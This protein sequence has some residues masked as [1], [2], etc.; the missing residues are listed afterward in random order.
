MRVLFQLSAIALRQV[1]GPGSDAAVHALRDR[2]DD[3]ST[4][5][6]DA[7]K[8]ANTQAWK[9]VEIALAGSSWWD[10]AKRTVASGDQAAFRG[11]VQKFLESTPPEQLPGADPEFRRL[12]LAELKDARRAGLL[13]GE[14]IPDTN[15]LSVQA[16]ALARF[17][18]PKRV[19][20]AEFE[21]IR[22]AAEDLRAH[23]YANLGRLVSL[24]P[25]G[26]RPLIVIAVEYFFR[27]DVHADPV[28]AAEFQFHELEKLSEQQ[29]A[30][31]SGLHLALTEQGDRLETLLDTAL[32]ILEE[33]RTVTRETRDDV[34]A[35][36]D[37]M[38]GYHQSFAQVYQA[39][40]RLV[41][42]PSAATAA[43]TVA[44][45][46]EPTEDK[47][48]EMRSLVE[49][50]GTMPGSEKRQH[51]A[52]FRAV[53]KLKATV[54]AY[55]AKRR[56]R[57]NVLP[58]ALFTGDADLPFAEP[59]DEPRPSQPPATAKSSIFG[60]IPKSKVRRAKPTDAKP[61]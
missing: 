52:L 47:I 13:P 44:A 24:R 61:E 56:L 46:P 11:Q 7:L 39:M 50:C 60:A 21:S 57:K 18:D 45:L 40:L 26:G 14:D 58:S 42:R 33:T 29:E 59:M 43:T 27:R 8:A 4:K 12:C 51:K 6:L 48:A 54:R 38:A 49:Q 28:L 36:R 53:G 55:D 31:F 9:A 20:E 23:G 2:Y 34:R 10:R 15:A 35:L 1:A 22:T 5:L 32:E 3:R 17:D 25:P 16:K 37:E 41:E 30:G 19:L